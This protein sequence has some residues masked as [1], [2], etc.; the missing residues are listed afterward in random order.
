MS[1]QISLSIKILIIFSDPNKHIF[2]KKKK[3]FKRN[4]LKPM[5]KIFKQSMPVKHYTVNLCV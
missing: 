5:I 4:S 2:Q 3:T 1:G